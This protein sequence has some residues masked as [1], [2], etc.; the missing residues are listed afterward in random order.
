MGTQ[1]R[2]WKHAS[3]SQIKTFRD[4]PR[5]WWW[6][7]I[8]GLPTP[9]SE[10]TEIG[11]YVHAILECRLKSGEWPEMRLAEVPRH[12][13][14]RCLSIAKKETPWLPREPVEARNV[15]LGFELPTPVV[16]IIGFIDWVEEHEGRIT[17]HKT[18]GN[19][20]YAKSDDD[21]LEDLQGALYAK[22]AHE[23]LKWEY[24]IGFRHLTLPS[25]E[26]DRPGMKSEAEFDQGMVDEAYEGALVDMREMQALA[27]EED[28][29]GVPA[30]Y[31]SCRKYGGC[32]FVDRCAAHKGGGKMGSLLDKLDV[33]VEGVTPV[34]PP[35][36][37]GG[38]AS[39]VDV[40]SM[41]AAKRGKAPAPKESKPDTHLAAILS[42]ESNPLP[43]PQPIKKPPL[44]KADEEAT[45]S[46][47]VPAEV[48]HDFAGGWA[49]LAKHYGISS[50]MTL[51]E[52]MAQ[53]EAASKGGA[54]SVALVSGMT[55]YINCAPRPRPGVNVTYVEEWI[56]PWLEQLAQEHRVSDLRMLSFGKGKFAL[57][58]RVLEEVKNGHPVPQHLVVDRKFFYSDALLESLIPLAA[59][60]VERMM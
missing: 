36:T 30:N 52:Y 43:D 3:V 1:N 8:V 40:E 23:V 57:V 6:N 18:S 29:E 21:L 34:T 22:A 10:A 44:P 42:K 35:E 48:S 50:G 12:L 58:E 19:L 28:P 7:K 26:P 41:L 45:A 51:G 14:E 47:K 53:K 11:S 60:V 55:L 16:P 27:K 38:A 46:E 4:C 56:S 54:G 9:S 5:K 24:P 32:P 49:E 17:D 59:F 20:S 31:K 33:K 25:R 13:W 39:S 37:R 2:P 15:E